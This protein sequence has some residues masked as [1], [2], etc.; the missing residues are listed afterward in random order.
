MVMVAHGKGSG[1]KDESSDMEVS[2]DSGEPGDNGDSGKNGGA[3]DSE[4][5]GESDDSE[6]G[7]DS[8]DNGNSDGSG[9]GGNGSSSDGGSGSGKTF[10]GQGTFFTP[11][12]DACTGKT[13]SEDDFIA[14]MHNEEG[15]DVKPPWCGRKACITYDGKDE[16]GRPGNVTV[17]LTDICPECKEGSLDLTPAAFK[18]LTGDLD[19]GRV[20]ISWQYC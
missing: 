17:T 14:A 19:I 10:K 13:S 7:G 3:D 1:G 9:D 4:D 6:D 2:D 11:D 5:S 16:G 18:K 15:N 12:N 20:E 8:E